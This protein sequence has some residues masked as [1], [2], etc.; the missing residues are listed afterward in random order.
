MKQ[1]IP[2]EYLE[3]RI[4]LVRGQK[5]MIDKDLAELY[6]VE[7]KMFNRAVKRNSDRF[8]PDI[9][10]QLTK[11]EAESLRFQIGTSKISGR[12]GRRY[13]PYVFGVS[14]EKKKRKIGF[15]REERGNG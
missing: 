10:F 4:Y 15:R 6:G 2:N 3:K 1:I 11:E 8:P 13:F 14:P 5:V 9:M 7:T 12:G